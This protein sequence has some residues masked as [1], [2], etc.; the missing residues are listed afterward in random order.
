MF[1][2]TV[3]QFAFLDNRLLNT[4]SISTATKTMEERTITRTRSLKDRGAVLKIGFR[5]GTYSVAIWRAKVNK[6]APKRYLF[7]NSPILNKDSFSDL[8]ART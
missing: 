8:I 6:T 3:I 2:L 5:N 4:F 7:E 1:L